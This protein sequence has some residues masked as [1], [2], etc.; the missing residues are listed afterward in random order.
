M[1][2]NEEGKL[3]QYKEKYFRRLRVDI[4]LNGLTA[5]CVV[6]RIRTAIKPLKM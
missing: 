1:R 5:V 2:A 6:C 4:D 3:S